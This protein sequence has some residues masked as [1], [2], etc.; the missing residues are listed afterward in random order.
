MAEMLVDTPGGIVIFSQCIKFPWIFFC[1]VSNSM[2]EFLYSGV[3]HRWVGVM[4]E[5]IS[6]FI[7]KVAPRMAS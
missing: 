2:F 6:G 4:A 1:T 3:R 5:V 7:R